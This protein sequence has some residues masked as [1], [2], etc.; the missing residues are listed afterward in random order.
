MWIEIETKTKRL[1]NQHTNGEVIEF[2][3]NFTSQV[4]DEIG[5]QLIDNHDTITKT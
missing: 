1:K 3:D 4:P 2:N 5:E